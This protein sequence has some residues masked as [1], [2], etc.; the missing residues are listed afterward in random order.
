MKKGQTQQIFV[1]LF[2][3]VLAISILFFGIDLFKKGEGLK[4]EVLLVDFFKTL[5]KRINNYYYLGIEST[6]VEE[7]ILPSG[8][9]EVCFIDDRY[10]GTDNHPEKNYLLSLKEFSDT[11]VFPK[12]EFKENRFNVSRLIVG[13]DANCIPVIGSRLNI[14]LVNRGVDGVEIELP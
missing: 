9:R 6:G 4:D 1:W 11:F 3:L 8:V 13:S 10:G 12:D 7:F 2:V 14:K 5:E